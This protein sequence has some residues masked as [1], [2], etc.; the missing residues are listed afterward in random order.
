MVEPAAVQAALDALAELEAS[1]DERRAALELALRQPRYEADRARRQYDAVEP[2]NRL[3]ASELERRWNAALEEVRRLEEE[4]CRLLP[5]DANLSE[6]EREE[7]LSLSEDLQSVWNN[8][9]T[10]MR[11]KKRLVR[12][13]IEEIIADVD[14]ERAVVELVI[15]WAGGYHTRLLVKKNRTGEHRFRTDRK[16]VEVVRELAKVT[17]DRDIAAILNRLGIKTGKGNT[18]TEARVRSLRN[19]H[20][21]PVFTDDGENPKW[22]TMKDAASLLGVSPTSVHRLI[23]EGVLP[24]RQ[25]VPCAPWMIEKHSLESEAVRQAVA[26]IKQGGKRPLPHHP[27]QQ[28][29]DLKPM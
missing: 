20:G 14:E 16:A 27:D 7:L 24:A 18:W 5:S 4:L 17:R 25:V 28:K 2:E 10:D 15:R 22:L 11:T 12:T 9:L 8:P 29:L 6:D 13:V 26:G 21:I 1:R 3:V 23:L 19:E